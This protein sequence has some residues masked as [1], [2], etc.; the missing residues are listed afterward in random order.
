MDLDKR[1]H[2]RLLVVDDEQE[3]IASIKRILSPLPEIEVIGCASGDDAINLVKNIT[4]AG[5]S[6]F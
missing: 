6:A 4:A 3:G 2:Y 5:E 1:N